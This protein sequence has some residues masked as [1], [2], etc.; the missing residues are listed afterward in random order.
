MADANSPGSEE[1]LTC[2]QRLSDRGAVAQTFLIFFFATFAF[3]RGL[4]LKGTW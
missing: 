4:R 1:H 3:V 2:R